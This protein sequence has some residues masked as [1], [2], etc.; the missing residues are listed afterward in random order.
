[1][2]F[3]MSLHDNDI[4]DDC[5]LVHTY[6]EGINTIKSLAKEKLGRELTAEEIE[7]INITREFN[8]ND[9]D[10]SYALI[11]STQNVNLE[12]YM[13]SLKNRGIFR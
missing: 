1:M 4:L 13:V 7:Q 3:I 2:L 8:S 5:Q 10:F 6:E 12:K 11:Q 9:T